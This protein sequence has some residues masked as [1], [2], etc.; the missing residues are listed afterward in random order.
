MPDN[1]IVN[2]YGIIVAP[3]RWRGYPEYAIW[4]WYL[5]VRHSQSLRER[6]PEPGERFQV[7][8][9]DAERDAWPAL[10]AVQAMILELGD[11]LR[12]NVQECLQRDLEKGAK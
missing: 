12:V 5:C 10:K 9:T 8:V 2:G 6:D 4:F 7:A 3:K 11:D 1:V